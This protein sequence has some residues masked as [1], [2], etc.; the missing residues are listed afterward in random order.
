MF[1]AVSSYFNMPWV[2]YTFIC[3]YFATTVTIIGV[4]LSENR[5]PLKSLAWVTVLFLLPI[6]GIILYLFFGRSIKNKRM[7]SRRNRRKLRKYEKSP[8]VDKHSLNLTDES[9]QMINLAGTLA[10][11]PYYPD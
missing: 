7:I 1:E 6:V 3:I 10:A 2:Y 8:N 11:S 5:N 9:L 4:I